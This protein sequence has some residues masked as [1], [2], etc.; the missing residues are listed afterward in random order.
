MKPKALSRIEEGTEVFIDS[1]IFIYHFIDASSECTDFLKRCEKGELFGVTSTN[2]L[3]EVLHRLMMFEASRKKL[4]A[5]P[6]IMKKLR[7]NPDKIGRLNDYFFSTHKIINM[8]VTVHPVTM[9]TMIKSHTMRVAYGLLVNDSILAA[10]MQEQGIDA[11]ATSD[12]DFSR[13]EGL[14]VFS[15]GDV[16]L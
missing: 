4:A 5:P 9:E 15:P 8:G 11:L 7:K 12:D 16:E 3:I 2:V 14:A 13:V 6:N 10:G 1:N